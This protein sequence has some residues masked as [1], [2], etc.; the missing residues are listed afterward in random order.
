ME[1]ET[2]T[3]NVADLDALIERKM[4]ERAAQASAPKVGTTLG[5]NCRADGYLEKT[6]HQFGCPYA[7]ASLAARK[8]WLGGEDA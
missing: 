8:N 3:I 1:D 2:V 7:A 6:F 4:S 5:C